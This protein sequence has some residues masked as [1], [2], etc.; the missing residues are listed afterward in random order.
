[1]VARMALCAIRQSWFNA[2]GV[3]YVVYFNGDSQN[4][5]ANL[6]NVADRWNAS[7]EVFAEQ[8]V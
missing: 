8:W 6:N 3:E 7:N 2:A 5:N 4:R 1:M